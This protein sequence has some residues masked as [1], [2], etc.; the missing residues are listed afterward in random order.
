LPGGLGLIHGKAPLY[1]GKRVALLGAGRQQAPIYMNKVGFR[2]LAYGGISFKP[3]YDH[4]L[5]PSSR[6]L[7]FRQETSIFVSFGI[8]PRLSSPAAENLQRT[9]KK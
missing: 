3:V 4:S 6:G 8:S 1:Y 9:E 5:T 2:D 7:L